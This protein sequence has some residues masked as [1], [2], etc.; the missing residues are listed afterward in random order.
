MTRVLISIAKRLWPDFDALADPDRSQLLVNLSGTIFS[1]PWV[2]G[3][4]VWL[5]YLTDVERIRDQWLLMLLFLGLSISLSRVSFFQVIKMGGEKYSHNSSNLSDITLVAS[6]FIFGPTAVW[7]YVLTTLVHF[8]SS[9]YRS[10]SR[11]QH[12]SWIRNLAYNL[13]ITTMAIL[14]GLTIYT[15]VGGHYPLA[16]DHLSDLFGAFIAVVVYWSIDGLLILVWWYSVYR[17]VLLPEFQDKAFFGLARQSFIFLMTAHIP[18]VFGILGAIIYTQVGLLIY[19]FFISGVFLVSLLTRRLSEAVILSQQKTGELDHLEQ[20]GRAIIA[21]PADASTLPQLL[22][23]YVPRMMIYQQLEIRLFE[24]QTLLQLPEDRPPLSESIWTWL[25][26]NSHPQ[27]YLVGEPLPW[28]IETNHHHLVLTPILSTEEQEPLGGICLVQ[29]GYQFADISTNL[30]P[31]LQVLAAQIASALNAAEVF[32]KTLEHQKVAQEL[33]FAGKIQ[34][35]FLPD[36]IPQVEGWQLAAKLLPARET[37]GDFYDLIPLPNGSLGIVVADVTDKGV[38]AALF[39]ALS[40]TLIRS[41]AIQYPSDPARVLTAANQRILMDTKSGLFVTTFYGVLTPV[42]G[43]LIYANAGH[44]PPYLFNSGNAIP[45]RILKATGVPLGLFEDKAW[46]QDA[47]EIKPKSILVL[48]SDGVTEA[49]NPAGEFFG[50]E[51]LL[52]VAGANLER[53]AEDMQEAIILALKE[54]VGE[55]PQSDDLTLVVLNRE[56]QA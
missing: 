31:A 6:Y 50:D 15:L 29:S 49:L 51:R 33:A 48:Y 28:E 14:I 24:G 7:L 42:S 25:Q 35:S 20:L 16:G 17:F 53:S 4:L 21:A 8:A 47:I 44:N 30:R 55:A 38:G 23:D 26:E 18:G 2:F 36:K 5:V 27:E 11:I 10:D 22:V 52:R 1:L 37:S 12:W 41:L 56:P 54:F 3:C 43:E 45:A 19:L 40:R 39:M 13:G 9:W 32:N 46:K 34:A